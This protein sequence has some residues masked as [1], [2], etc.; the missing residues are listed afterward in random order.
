MNNQ[1]KLGKNILILSIMTLLT[2]F[3]WVGFEVYHAYTKTTV[4]QVVQELIKPLN[5]A[6]NQAVVEEI[7]K[8]YQPSESELEIISVPLP[9]PITELETGEEATP[10]QTATPSGSLD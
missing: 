9:S 5:P 6:L 4:P 7:E 1:F 2:V 8:K 10:S 3:T